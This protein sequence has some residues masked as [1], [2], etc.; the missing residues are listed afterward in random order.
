MTEAKQEDGTTR[1]RRSFEKSR[2]WAARITR[3][4]VSFRHGRR[5][6][7]DK[8][9]ATNLPLPLELS[10]LVQRRDLPLSALLRCRVLLLRLLVILLAFLNLLLDKSLLRVLTI[11]SLC[12][13]LLLRLLFRSRC[14]RHGRARPS[15]DGRQ[16]LSEP[17]ELEREPRA[18]LLQRRLLDRFEHIPE[19][20]E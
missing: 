17:L 11:L 8:Q 19:Q 3:C 13:L 1:G 2:V 12:Y 15:S 9:E 10:L 6:R 20:A 4:E 7:Q 16:S 5:A 18:D 14:D